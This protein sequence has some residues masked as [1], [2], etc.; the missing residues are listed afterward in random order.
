M[1]SASAIEYGTAKCIVFAGWCI[2]KDIADAGII[3][4]RQV[5]TANLNFKLQKI[6]REVLEAMK[7]L[8]DYISGMSARCSCIL[9]KKHLPT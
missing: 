9:P 8:A 3:L 1:G 6:R 7:L 5:N 2:H 4:Y